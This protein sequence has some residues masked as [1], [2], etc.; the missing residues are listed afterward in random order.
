MRK[1]SSVDVQLSQTHIHGHM[2]GHIHITHTIT[3][4]TGAEI[5]LI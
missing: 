3:S 1:A 2:H 4:K 5:S